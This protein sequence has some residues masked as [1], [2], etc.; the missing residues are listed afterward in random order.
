[1]KTIKHQIYIYILNIPEYGVTIESLQYMTE[2]HLNNLSP[3]NK[4]YQR[5]IFE[6]HLI[7]WQ[8]S[9]ITVSY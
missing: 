2:N 6:H 3:K 8:A 9:F 5:I 4:Y 7:K 1:M